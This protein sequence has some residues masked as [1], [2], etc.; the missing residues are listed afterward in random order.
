MNKIFLVV[1]VITLLALSCALPFGDGVLLKDDFSKPDSGWSSFNTDNASA[2]YANGDYVIKV[3]RETWFSWGNA[4]ERN[5][6]NVHIEVTAKNFGKTDDVV[7]G[8]ICAYQDKSH[9]YYL[10]IDWAGSYTIARLNGDSSDAEVFLTN[11]NRWARSDDIPR[12]AAS[13]RLGADCGN[14]ALTL[15]VDGKQIASVKDSTFAKGDVGLFVST[16]KTKNVEV[17]FDDFVVTAK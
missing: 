17:R 4:S 14:G 15:Y 9:Y 11:N 12:K 10:G 16:Q 1:T 6:S 8:I 3:F 7:F 5:L 2:Q 13:Y